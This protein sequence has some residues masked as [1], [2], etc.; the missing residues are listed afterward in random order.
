M[1]RDIP[2]N[3]SLLS[4]LEEEG[5]LRTRAVRE[6]ILSSP[7]ELFVWDGYRDEAYVDWPLPLGRTGQT[8]SAPHMVT[9]MLEELDLRAGMRV[10]EIGSGS[11]WNAACIASIVGDRGRVVSVELIEEL[12]EF[13]TRNIRRAGLEKIVEI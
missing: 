11:G 5:V 3:A 1:T 10:L 8:I 2:T 13:A 6:A 4:R 9:M 7:R 12:V